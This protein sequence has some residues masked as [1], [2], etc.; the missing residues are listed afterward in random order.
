[1]IYYTTFRVWAD[2]K[3]CGP[4]TIHVIDAILR[5]VLYH[6]DCAVL[7]VKTVAYQVD[8]AAHRKVIIGNLRG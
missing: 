7:P 8:E 5:I 2:N 1:V 4:V 3:G 6:N